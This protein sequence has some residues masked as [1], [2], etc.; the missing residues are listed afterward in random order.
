MVSPLTSF[1]SGLSLQGEGRINKVEPLARNP[2]Y[3]EIAPQRHF[4]QSLQVHLFWVELKL[5]PYSLF[6]KMR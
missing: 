3:I 2:A 4:P 5:H 6:M 1:P